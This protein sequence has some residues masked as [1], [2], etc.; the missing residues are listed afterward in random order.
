VSKDN[1]AG[2][3]AGA[4]LVWSGARATARAPFPFNGSAVGLREGSRWRT[5]RPVEG[6]VCRAPLQADGDDAPACGGDLR[7]PR[8]RNNGP[9]G[10]L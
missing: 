7:P 2:R 9:S 4:G 1:C 8:H 10:W 5:F 3:P 6:T